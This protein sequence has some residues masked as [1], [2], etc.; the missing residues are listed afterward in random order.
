MLKIYQE[1]IKYQINLFI[2]DTLL[3]PKNVEKAA[4]RSPSPSRVAPGVACVRQR[5]AL[6]ARST[7][8]ACVQSPQRHKCP[9]VAPPTL[10][11]LRRPSPVLPGLSTGGS[12]SSHA[13]LLQGEG[14]DERNSLARKSGRQAP[15]IICLVV[16]MAWRMV[17]TGC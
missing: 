6:H 8:R 9:R 15:Y 12:R 5:C 1:L 2:Y 14:W 4:L 13:G 7:T 17:A 10:P 11:L 16:S 3:C